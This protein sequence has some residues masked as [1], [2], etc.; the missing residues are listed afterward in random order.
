MNK[1]PSKTQAPPR[2]LAGGLVRSSARTAGDRVGPRKGRL[3]CSLGRVRA[4]CPRWSK[5]VCV[6]VRACAR[7]RTCVACVYL[8]V[9]ACVRA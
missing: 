2:A 3:G 4:S 5:C 6:C 9:R 8:C 1:G 7:V